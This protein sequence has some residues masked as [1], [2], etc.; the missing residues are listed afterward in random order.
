MCVFCCNFGSIKK[1]KTGKEIE[2][3]TCLVEA[4]NLCKNLIIRNT[5]GDIRN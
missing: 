5:E 1:R 3:F 4:I 2:R